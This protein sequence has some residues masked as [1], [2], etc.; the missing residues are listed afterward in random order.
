[1]VQARPVRAA[2]GST[3]AAERLARRQI[4]RSTLLVPPVARTSFFLLPV[5]WF[6]GHES[7]GIFVGLW[8]PSIVSFG[9]RML[10]GHRTDR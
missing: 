2:A 4:A 9:A 7:Q 3:G 1:M 5:R 8:V 6:S 10:A